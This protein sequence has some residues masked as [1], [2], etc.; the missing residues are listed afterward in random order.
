MKTSEPGIAL[1]KTREVF[2]P[3]VYDDA[4]RYPQP[5]LESWGSLH[6]TATMGY[7]TLYPKGAPLPHYIS[8]PEADARLRA[9]LVEEEAGVTRALTFTPNQHEFDALVSFRYNEGGGALNGSSLLRAINA[10]ERD[11][12]AIAG[13]FLLW[14]KWRPDKSGPL[15][16]SAGLS[17]RRAREAALFSTPVP[18][19][20]IDR[21]EILARV[22][23]SAD[24]VLRGFDWREAA[25][26]EDPPERIS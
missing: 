2:M 15:V 11:P 9:R 16:V 4:V 25:T 12:N 19:E 18:D 22:F 7:G 24:E 3:H 10:G 17:I 1:I 26:V 13:L 21:A 20:A 8:E 14:N 23:A 5:P 6:G